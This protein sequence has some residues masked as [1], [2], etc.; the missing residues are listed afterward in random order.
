MVSLLIDNSGSM[1][2]RPIAVAAMCADILARTLERCGVKV[3][4]LG[5]HHAQL[6]GRPEPRAVAARGQAAQS[7][8]PQR[9]APHR[10]QAGRQPLAARAAQPRPDAARGAAQGEHRR[11]GDPVGAPAPARRGRSSASILMVI[12]DGAPVDDSTLSANPGNYLEQHLRQ[13]IEWIETA[14]AGRAVGDRHR[15][16]RDPL[17][18]A[19]GHDLRPRAARR[20]D[21]GRARRSCS[22]SSTR[23]LRAPLRGSAALACSP[24][25]PR[26]AGLT[27][28]RYARTV[29]LTTASA[30]A[31]GARGDGTNQRHQ[32]GL[33]HDQT[34][35]AGAGAVRCCR[36]SQARPRPRTC[37]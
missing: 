12:S 17:L 9:P 18:S 11:R 20:R 1:R 14:L 13:V 31:P 19:R 5:L 3:E 26:P 29:S 37:A 8:P 30:A 23:P 34:D 21:A 10:L 4:I 15:P 16:R 25:D 6:E 32:E 27:G 22:I 33:R 28:R 35:L 2:G 24:P 7:R 36:L